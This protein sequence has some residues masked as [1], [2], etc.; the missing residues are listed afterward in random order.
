MGGFSQFSVKNTLF[1]SENK[2]KMG[3]FSGKMRGF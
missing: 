1:L 3:G 2:A